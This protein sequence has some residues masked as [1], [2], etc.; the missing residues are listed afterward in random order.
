MTKTGSEAFLVWDKE[1]KKPDGRWDLDRVERS[2]RMVCP[3]CQG[4][5]LDSFKTRMIAGGEWRP[6]AT[7]EQGFR[8]RQLSSLY[9]AAPETTWGKLAV[10]FLQAKASLLGL[11]GFINGDLAEPYES[12]DRQAERVELITSRLEVVNEWKKLGTVDCQI[13]HFW[14]VCRAWSNGNSQ[15]I[16]AGRFSTLD[17]IRHRQEALKIDDVGMIV[18]SGFG[19]RS[20]HEIYRQCA[21]F[22]TLAPR[23][24]SRPLAI[25]WM[26]SKGMPGRKRWKDTATGLSVPY[27]LRDIDPFLGTSEA[28]K[29]SMS[30]F[31]FSGDFFEDILAE[32]RKPGGPYSWA[33]AESMATDE[34]WRHMDSKI[35]TAVYNRFSG[36]TTWEYRK[37]SQ[38]WPDHMRDC[39]VMQIAAAV[40]FG[41]LRI[42]I[43]DPTNDRN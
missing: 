32:M 2:A 27:Y 29:I 39:E 31:E 7:A 8:S 33:V 15:G 34:Y 22:C 9:A 26:P 24:M 40:F 4:D 13:D 28:G 14:F 18:D 21:R 6:T 12:Q 20:D 42:E 36:R 35:K 19:A 5:I 10:K 37:R 41:L 30:L 17:D 25:G 23:A 3:H 1:A 16:E 38:T 11:Q 43:E